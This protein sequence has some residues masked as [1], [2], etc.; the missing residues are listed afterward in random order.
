MQQHADVMEEPRA[1]LRSAAWAVFNVLQFGFTLV[2]TA[3]W[4]TAALVVV[5]TTG[6]RDTALRMAADGWAPGLLGGAGAELVIEGRERVDPAVTYL[7]VSNHQSVID[8]CALFR[9]VPQPLRFLLKRE[10]TKVPFVGR[11][12]R[13]CEMLFITRDDRR[14]GPQLRRDAAAMLRA[15]RSL[16]LFPEGTRSRDG[17]MAPFKAGSLQAAIDA[18]VAVVPVAL[19]GA[20]AVLPVDGFFRVR[21]G[22]IRVSIGRPIDS[23]GRDRQSLAEEAQAAVAA[24]LR[25]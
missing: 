8:V 12:A 7:F 14:S 16:C 6:R 9:A 24:M 22:T 1:S 4:I 25:S 5:W 19:D 3:A 11:Y 18:G 17:R 21:P 23:A 10:M 13:A 15:G 20:G 2:W